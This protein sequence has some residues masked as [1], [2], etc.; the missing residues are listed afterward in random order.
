MKGEKG[1]DKDDDELGTYQDSDTWPN[2]KNT[3]SPE[4]KRPVINQ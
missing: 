2:L 4:S 1:A 3:L